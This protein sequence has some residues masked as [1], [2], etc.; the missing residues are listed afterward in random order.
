[1]SAGPFL[2]KGP[3]LLLW[4]VVA[5]HGVDEAVV[6]RL[7]GGQHPPRR[8]VVLD[9]AAG[10][11]GDLDQ[12]QHDLLQLAQVLTGCRGHLV[13]G[14]GHPGRTRFGQL[15]P[16][17]PVG[18]ALIGGGQHREHGAA[19]L[20]GHHGVHR[21]GHRVDHV[22]HRVRGVQVTAGAGHVQLHRGRTGRVQGEQRRRD[23]G[24]HL[25]G[26]RAAD[27]HDPLVEKA[28]LEPAGQAGAGRR[29]GG[30][31]PAQGV[32]TQVH[33]G[34]LGSPSARFRGLPLRAEELP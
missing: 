8:Q 18:R 10:L 25:A 4:V 33:P 34:S 21:R 6:A 30:G 20:G 27:H 3:A 22:D 11:P 5:D 31:L 29:I 28:F 2:V 32:V 7:G 9:P 1:V 26:E 15:E 17:V 16:G 14:P 19:G 12:P 23:A 13:G 24:G